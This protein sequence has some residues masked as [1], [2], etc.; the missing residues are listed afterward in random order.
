MDELHLQV[1]HCRFVVSTRPNAIGQLDP[2]CATNLPAVLRPLLPIFFARFCR[3]PT[4]PPAKL[5][6]LDAPDSRA[7]LYKLVT[8]DARKAADPSMRSAARRWRRKSLSKRDLLSFRALNKIGSVYAWV[9][10]RSL[11]AGRDLVPGSVRAQRWLPAWPINLANIDGMTVLHLSVQF[12]RLELAAHLIHHGAD[13]NLADHQGRSA[14]HWAAI[15]FH[16]QH[17]LPMVKLLIEVGANPNARDLAG[18]TPLHYAVAR[19]YPQIVRALL[20]HGA[21]PG[22]FDREGMRARD[23]ISRFKRTAANQEIAGIFDAYDQLERLDDAL[24]A[25]TCAMSRCRL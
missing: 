18:R 3:S 13:V 10:H 1:S 22:L 16:S 21:H 6:V 11:R 24:P 9:L 23:L 7:D 14:L 15:D 19:D 4:P 25:A 8:R 20:A 12:H 2:Q 17:T 5:M